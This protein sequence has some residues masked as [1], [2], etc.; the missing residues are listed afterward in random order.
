MHQFLHQHLSQS[1]DRIPFLMGDWKEK[2]KG[3]GTSKKLCEQFGLVNVWATLN[4]NHLEF[5]TYHRGSR[6][7]DYM[8]ATPA[9]ISHIATMLYEP[10]YYRVPWGGDHRG[11]YVDIDTSAIFSNDHTSSAYM[12][13]GILSKDRISVP[14]YLQAFRNHI[15]ENNI[16][17]N[18]K[19][20]YSN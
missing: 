4:P 18:T 1:P 6:R 10:F 2:C 3:N 7:I 9:A 12:K 17:R 5:P 13:W 11:F 20:L 8:L 14:I 19:L 16:Y 15:I